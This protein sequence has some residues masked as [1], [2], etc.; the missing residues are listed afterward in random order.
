[1]KVSTEPLP[2]RELRLVIQPD[3]EEVQQALRAAARNI[4]RQA[5]IP[6]FRKGKVPHEV[7]V[8]RFGEDVLRQEAAER[9]VKKLYP[10]A[11]KQEGIKPYAQAQLEEVQ[12][13]P[14]A[15][16]LTVPL[17]PTVNLGDYRR[18][19]MKPQKVKVSRKMVRAALE[20]LR[21]EKAVL[22]PAGDRPAKLGDVAVLD[23]EGEIPGETVFL[24]DENA[25]VLLKADAP[26]PAPGF[27][28]EVVGMR[29][30]EERT[31]S[32]PLS[33]DFPTEELR[34]REA[35]FTILLQELYERILPRLDN[36]LARTIGK[37]DSLK[38]LRKH[39][40]GKLLLQAQAKADEEYA[41]AVVDA[42]VGQATV[43]FPPV[44]VEERL[45]EM[46]K[47]I[48]R[49]LREEAKLTLENYLTIQGKT[50]EELRDE[51]RPR[52]EERLKWALVL[53]EVVARE[54]LEVEEEELTD[55]IE[56]ISEPW[57]I[58]ADEMREALRSPGGELAIVSSLLT[59]KAIE[60][61]VA[62]AKGETP[63]AQPAP[64]PRRW[65]ERLAAIT[66]RKAP[67]SSEQPA[68]ERG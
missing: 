12:H 29:E 40:K 48:E 43:E 50:E 42:I 30:G 68:D 9:L 58:R 37:F 4:S 17:G 22:E 35:E 2:N 56:E 54:R 67:P 34:G 46:L 21:Q 39:L 11:L 7:I 5:R 28:Q 55:R 10:Q 47:G 44:M 23:I 45:D 26:F 36:D 62:I 25:R 33:D 32:L 65:I 15:F 51:L 41:D 13:K 38:E 66:K 64:W 53:S 3:E 14:M 27:S 49:R 52:A 19:R 20:V 8:E 61:L 59:R 57:G 63:L 60:R 6:G 16:R 18:F 31:F 1:M 24:H